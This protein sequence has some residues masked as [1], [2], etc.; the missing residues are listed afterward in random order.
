MSAIIEEGKAHSLLS[1]SGSKRWILCPASVS[2]CKDLPR[3]EGNDAALRGTR[4]HYLG[5]TMLNSFINGNADYLELFKGVNEVLGDSDCNGLFTIET[6]MLTEARNYAVYC[7]NL[8]EH[9]DLFDCEIIAELNVD[10]S[11]IAPNTAGHV[12]CVVITPNSSSGYTLNIIDLKTGSTLVEAVGNSQMRLYAYGT[13]L[14]FKDQYEITE[15]SM[16]IY[17][18]NKRAGKHI[19]VETLSVEQLNKWIDQ[20]VKPAAKLALSD[21]APCIAG[22]E[23]CQWCPASS[24]CKEAHDYGVSIMADMFGD[25]DTTPTTKKE[26]VQFSNS[27]SLTDISKF[28]SRLDFIK[29]LEK[30]YSQ[31]IEE[32]LKQ[33]KQVNGYKL[34]LSNHNRKWTNELEAY[35]KLKSWASIDEVA[36]RK[37]ITVSQMETVLGNMGVKKQNIFNTLWVKPEGTPVL[38]KESDKRP[39][40][41]AIKDEF[42]D[43]DFDDVLN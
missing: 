13:I 31:R 1:P 29:I 22:E 25:L 28:L 34:V 9:Y 10:L 15:V 4:I 36:P 33:G 24:F 27:V 16:H 6:D 14:K 17:Q 26:V 30:N 19:P 38:A 18:N 39:A 40:V 2:K 20:K 37:L 8:T 32:E 11:D 23:Q 41:N 35:E 42:E 21:K 5:E 3:Q 12:D 43:L 7:V